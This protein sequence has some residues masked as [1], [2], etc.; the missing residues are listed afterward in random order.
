MSVDAGSMSK[1]Q[2]A[3]P[4]FHCEVVEKAEADVYNQSIFWCSSKHGGNLNRSSVF[5]C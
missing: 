1:H 2:S 5:L 4:L 3:N